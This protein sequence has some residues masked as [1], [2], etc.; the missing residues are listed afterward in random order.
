MPKADTNQPTKMPYKAGFY[1][2][3]GNYYRS[4]RDVIWKAFPKAELVEWIEEFIANA[5][6]EMF[7]DAKPGDGEDAQTER[8]KLARAKLNK[9][10]S[11]PDCIKALD[12]QYISSRQQIGK[13][14]TEVFEKHSIGVPVND[15]VFSE[16]TAWHGK[17]LADW[18]TENIPSA[19]FMCGRV[20]AINDEYSYADLIGGIIDI[21][22]KTYLVKP[23]LC[24]HSYSDHALELAALLNCTHIYNQQSDVLEVMPKVDGAL[25]VEIR[26]D[27]IFVAEWFTSPAEFEAWTALLKL[28]EWLEQTPEPREF[29]F[30]VQGT[31]Q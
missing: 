14:T 12:D 13:K 10:L 9:T 15:L 16:T 30:E 31:N 25:I 20:T 28:S 19:S 4:V 21:G 5:L 2:V 11:N 7:I 1:G 27:R 26:D 22:G 6:N 23:R 3:R 8:V 29:V 17:M 24:I 18:L